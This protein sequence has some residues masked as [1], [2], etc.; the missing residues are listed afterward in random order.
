MKKTSVIFFTLL[1]FTSCAT[2]LNSLYSFD[3][4]LT[5][6]KAYSKNTNLSVNIPKGWFTAEDNECNCI[7]LW[8]IKDDFSQSLNFSI[9]NVDEQTQNDIR[10]SGIQKL[11]EYN[12]IFTRAKFGKE[13]KGF[14]NEENFIIGDRQFFAYQYHDNRDKIVR[15][16]IFQLDNL[17]Y[18]FTAI[19]KDSNNN[20]ELWVIQNTVLTS[21]N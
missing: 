17:F 5:S 20:E 13:F 18:E 8:L 2:S 9:I 7:D 12:K 14:L 16:V 1:L 19:S 15:V 3:Y 6:Q 10:K 11:V 4:P 21:I